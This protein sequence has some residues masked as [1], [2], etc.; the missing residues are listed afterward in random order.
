MITEIPTSEFQERIRRVQA[1]LARRGLDALLTFGS[2]A[3]PQFVRYLADHWPAFETAAVL[4]PVEGEAMLL[5]GPE[6]L[7]YAQVRSKIPVIRQILEYRESSEPEYPGKPLD[8]FAS[9]FNE[10]SGGKGVH[11][12]GIVGYP[13]TPVPVYEGIRAAMA[14]CEIVRADDILIQMRMVKSENELALL[15][16]AF[17]I[18]EK[19]IEAVL[20]RIKPGMMEVEVVGIAQE[21]MYRHGAEY[22]GHPLYVLSGRNSANAIGRPTLKKLVEG[23]VIQL[24]FG[25]RFGGYSSS[26]GRPVVLGHMPD[27]VRGL[28][29][30]GLDA[31]D[32][33]MEVIKAGVEARHVAQTV[34]DYIT[35]RGYGPNI[36]YG[37][38]HG[39]GLME[40]EHPWMETNSEYVLRENYTFQV[41][42]FLYTPQY[43]AR[44]EDGIRVT[45]DGV[46]RFSTYRREII[47]I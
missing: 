44:W 31:A 23:E 33:T 21:V 41:D 24:N 16:E 30:M 8:T 46:E 5:I 15:R 43:G 20:N 34:Q 13:I 26:V 37:P 1:E 22:E 25:A 45:R 10:V 14:G 38:C 35:A 39:I 11:R 28:L 19:A 7:T 32:K 6:S 12:L 42:S 18:S 9:V 36:L 29:Q 17:R 4:I 47:V 27:D 40:C 2:E 3:E